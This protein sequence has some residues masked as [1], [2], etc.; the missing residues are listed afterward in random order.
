LVEETRALCPG[1]ASRSEDRWHG[2]YEEISRH[3]P[4]E[5]I[6]I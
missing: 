5:F 2:S 4:R 6:S 1:K 3:L